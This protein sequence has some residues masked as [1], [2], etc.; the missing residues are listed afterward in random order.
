MPNPSVF[1][2]P[3][4]TSNVASNPSGPVI[5]TGTVTFT[6]QSTGQT[7]GTAP[8]SSGQATLTTSTLPVGNNIITTTY[9]GDSNFFAGG[10]GSLTQVVNK[11]DTTTNL[12]S[13]PNIGSKCGQ[14][15]VFVT[16]VSPA[17][18]GAG[19]P[20]G[21]VTYTDVTTGQ[22][23]AIVGLNTVNGATQDAFITSALTP[24]NHTIQATYSGDANFN[25]SSATE[26]F[27]VGK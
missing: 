15:V 21:T 25:G 1:G 11:A 8:I 5:P 20:T 22:T 2:Q 13:S 3:V 14:S 4:F 6:N 7:L 24:G 27:E 26:N 17:P 18:P 10:G 23:L 19:A 9:S 12:T 16:V